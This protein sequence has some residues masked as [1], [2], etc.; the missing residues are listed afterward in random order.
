MKAVKKIT[1]GFR[2][3]LPLAWRLELDLEIGDWVEIAL[4]AKRDD[5]KEKDQAKSQKS[6]T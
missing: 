6:E 1:S 3:V 2:V 5:L 4:V